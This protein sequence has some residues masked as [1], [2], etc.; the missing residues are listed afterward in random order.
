MALLA[1]LYTGLYPGQN[2]SLV[3][4]PQ[5]VQ[6]I[7]LLQMNRAELDVFIAQEMEKNPLLELASPADNDE[8]PIAD[9]FSPALSEVD[10]VGKL[11][12]GEIL[13]DTLDGDYA[14]VFPDDLPDDMAGMER[15]GEDATGVLAQW[16]SMPGNSM[17]VRHKD[18][19]GGF[20]DFLAGPVSLRDHLNQQIPFIVTSP[21]ERLIAGV[22]LDHLDEA[23]YMTG[24]ASAIAANLGIDVVAIEAVL[25]RLQDVEPPGL[26]ARSLSECLAIQLR[27][28]N[29][30]DPAMEALLA[31]L[32]KLAQRD[33]PALKR[34]CGVSEEDLIDM[35]AEIRS[36]DP[37]PGSAFIAFGSE[38]VVPDILVRAGVDGSWHV[39]LNPQALP[40]VLVN[41]DYHARI[42]QS[43]RTSKDDRVFLNQS[44]QDAN[45]LARS[46][47][48]RAKTIV[49]VAVEIVRQQG[50]FLANGVIDLRPLTLKTVAEAIKMHESTISRVTSNKYMLTP[51]GLFELKY[52][53]SNAIVSSKGG[54]DHSAEAV[55]DTIRQMIL[56]ETAKTV[57]SD[58]D[59][60]S[61]LKQSGIELAR[62]T[63]A[64]YREAMNIPSSV[65]RKR[66][67]RARAKAQD[68]A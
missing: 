39:E 13:A 68:G 42:L 47:D 50:G 56:R 45:W 36:L 20:D 54:Q 21:L 41:N 26:F 5:L 43:S 2:Q 22:L 17:P 51:R 38:I 58:D 1:S 60:V 31:N 23:G 12:Q 55:R 24:D 52:F 27:A 34:L 19:S 44:L 32:E 7:R 28:R 9:D 3:M 57:L 8:A 49:K 35:F 37:K 16:K 15:A 59:V 10:D 67:K 11:A 53:F 40:Q 48:Q 63:V 6:S 33:F 46:L 18:E 61:R 29:R 14:S 62:R 30:F 4:T 25:T 65:Q 64:K 66:E